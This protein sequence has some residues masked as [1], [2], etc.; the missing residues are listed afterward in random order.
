MVETSFTR[1]IG[2]PPSLLDVVVVVPSTFL[3]TST[4]FCISS[5]VPSEMRQCVFSKGGKSRPTSTPAVAAG[6]AEPG[7]GPLDVHEQEVGVA[8]RCR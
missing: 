7:G 6:V 1:D 4:A 8:S 3:N 5:I 2:L